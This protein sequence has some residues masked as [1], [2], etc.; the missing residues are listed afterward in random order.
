MSAFLSWAEDWPW[1]KSPIDIIRM[2]QVHGR[3]SFWI[4]LSIGIHIRTI[5][6][7]R[8]VQ[9][10]QLVKNFVDICSIIRLELRPTKI[11]AEN[12]T[13]CLLMKFFIN[14]IV[15]KKLTPACFQ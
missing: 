13:F 6:I 12:Q 15:A 2:L 7:C 9:G 14:V 8:L 10:R 4:Q 1:L 5:C 11:L 3:A